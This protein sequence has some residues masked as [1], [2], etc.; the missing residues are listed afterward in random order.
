MST[1]REP[2]A[3]SLEFVEHRMLVE[4]DDGRLIG[5]PLEW[6]PRLRDASEED[7]RRWE[8]IGDGEGIYWPA[9]DEHLS[10]RGFLALDAGPL[11]AA[12]R[13]HRRAG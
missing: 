6:F 10:V 9:V 7:R 13:S 8:L 2:L 5:L 12:P 11:S 4:L 1:S 3:T